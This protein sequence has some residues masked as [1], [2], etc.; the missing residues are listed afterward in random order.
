METSQIQ[1]MKAHVKA[2]R[3]QAEKLDDRLSSPNWDSLNVRHRLDV[4]ES[5]IVSAREMLRAV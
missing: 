1:L 3:E 5:H 2:A 4:I